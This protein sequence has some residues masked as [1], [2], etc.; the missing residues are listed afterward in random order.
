MLLTISREK[1]GLLLPELKLMRQKIHLA[2]LKLSATRIIQCL[3]VIVSRDS[4]LL[5]FKSEAALVHSFAD[6]VDFQL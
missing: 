6:F 5:C 3:S 2:C 4:R 1:A